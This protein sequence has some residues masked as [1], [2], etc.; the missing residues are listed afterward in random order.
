MTLNMRSI[1]AIGFIHII[2]TVILI[3]NE[4]P[5]PHL[6]ILGDHS[7]AF[8]YS[9][10]DE[11]GKNFNKLYSWAMIDERLVPTN[12]ISGIDLG[13]YDYIEAQKIEIK[14]LQEQSRYSGHF[15]RIMALAVSAYIIL[16]DMFAAHST[17]CIILIIY[18]VWELGPAYWS[19]LYYK[20]LVSI[21]IVGL[22]CKFGSPNGLLIF[23]SFA[24]T[25]FLLFKFYTQF[26]YEKLATKTSINSI[27]IEFPWKSFSIFILS[28]SILFLLFPNIE[29][30]FSPKGLTNKIKDLDKKNIQARENLQSKVNK[31]IKKHQIFPDKIKQLL[32]NKNLSKDM[33]NKLEQYQLLQNKL[34]NCFK[35]HPFR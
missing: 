8:R 21:G 16:K 17:E 2:F 18:A 33:I 35:C 5:I 12:D 14:Q 7:N 11:I 23:G 19:N 1:K 32:K 24:F 6:A 10:L 29:L 22:F 9:F 30:P 31:H 34:K 25:Y 13:H 4:I 27:K 15:L 3:G 28:F 26:Y 20:H